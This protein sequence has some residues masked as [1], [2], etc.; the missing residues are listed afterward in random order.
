MIKSLVYT[1]AL[2]LI[3]FYT[4]LQ[5]LLL[6]TDQSKALNL[7]EN[8]TI[9]ITGAGQG[10]GHKLTHLF[11]KKT[12]TKLILLCY[13]TCP[14]N[15]DKQ[16]KDRV[17]YHK[18]DF[19]SGVEH[20]ESKFKSIFQE[21]ENITGLINNAGM[22]DMQRF[23]D[24]NGVSKCLDIMNINFSAHVIL[25]KVFVDQNFL[26][27]KSKFLVNIGSVVSHGAGTYQTCYIASKHAIQG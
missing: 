19:R 25:T 6:I 23:Y 21:N 8:D 2:F 22:T 17:I 5:G 7:T 11:L 3:A 26:S 14:S 18:I 4:V 9:V 24:Q 16:Y 10:L 20:L 27:K 1:V 15:I 13:H 12:P